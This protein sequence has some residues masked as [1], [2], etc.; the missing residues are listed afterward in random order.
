MP[1]PPDCFGDRLCMT[2][3]NTSRLPTACTSAILRRHKPSVCSR[4]SYTRMAEASAGYPT[5]TLPIHE[6]ANACSTLFEDAL[7]QFET[8]E[9]AH[10]LVQDLRT[11]FVR[12]TAY[13]GA[14]PEA[15]A[16][17]DSRLALT[18]TTREMILDLLYMLRQNLEW[19]RLHQA[20]GLQLIAE[21]SARGDRVGLAVVGTAIDRLFAITQ[22]LRRKSSAYDAS[23]AS[24]V[25]AISVEDCT[26]MMQLRLPGAPTSLC[27]HISR[28]VYLRTRSMGYLSQLKDSK[29]RLSEALEVQ[30]STRRED[31]PKNHG[32]V[33][34]RN[35]DMYPPLP[36]RTAFSSIVSCPICFSPIEVSSLTE[37]IWRS[38]LLFVA[39]GLR[40]AD[41]GIGPTFEGTSSL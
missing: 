40:C 33:L 39:N 6:A 1:A 20:S 31:E 3:P 23:S 10:S 32:Q 2:I 38:V 15:R 27:T 22:T 41:Q 13:A 28:A 26:K 12:W 25:C 18:Q 37:D 5:H 7:K 11:L 8:D 17:L 4:P 9:S 24:S 16:P 34:Q 19:A 21:T 35:E 30:R 36:G 14:R 29:A